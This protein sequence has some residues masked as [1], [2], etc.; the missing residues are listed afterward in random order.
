MPTPEIEISPW[1]MTVEVAPD[2]LVTVTGISGNSYV[3]EGG[4]GLVSPTTA[5]AENVEA[6]LPILWATPYTPPTPPPSPVTPLQ[7]RRALNSSG[8]REMVE[9][10][11]LAA[12]QDARDAWDYAT[13][14]KRDDP[15][16]TAMGAALGLAPTQ[17]DNLFTLAA[18]FN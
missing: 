2:V 5:N 16:L 7:I 8:M 10:A 18:T 3:I 6:E 15:T 11:L 1:P 9:A 13:E 12:P 17:I 14:V 4:I